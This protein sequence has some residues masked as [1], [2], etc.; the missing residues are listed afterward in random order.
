MKN[1]NHRKFS[2][3]PDQEDS[4]PFSNKFKYEAEIKSVLSKMERVY[5]IISVQHPEDQRRERIKQDLDSLQKQ[6]EDLVFWE[7]K[8]PEDTKM[9]DQE[10]YQLEKVNELKVKKLMTVSKSKF[11][12]LKVNYSKILEQVDYEQADGS[13]DAEDAEKA[14]R[15]SQDLRREDAASN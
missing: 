6:L 1:I 9:S 10:W 13:F 2:S 5:N 3:Q 14:D 15:L 12:M 8:L 11:Y 4:S 7:E